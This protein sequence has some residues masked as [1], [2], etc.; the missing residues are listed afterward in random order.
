MIDKHLF[1]IL[2]AIFL[3]KS[4]YIYV[5]VN[6]RHLYTA[7]L[8]NNHLHLTTFLKIESGILKFNF[9][10]NDHYVMHCVIMSD[11][12]VSRPFKY[13]IYSRA[14]LIRARIKGTRLKREIC[15]QRLVSY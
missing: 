13:S 15:E 6:D 10:A 8:I 3:Y 5:T 7:L 2:S 12:R 4:N 11:I 14:L 9:N 1:E